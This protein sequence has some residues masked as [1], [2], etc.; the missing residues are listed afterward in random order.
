M[1]V[2]AR[3]FAVLLVFGVAVATAATP[4]FI[5][6][7]GYDEDGEQYAQLFD[8]HPWSVYD[9]FETGP[10]DVNLDGRVDLA[11]LNIVL[12]SMGKEYR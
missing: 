2:G 8:H 5:E 12:A 7:V 1:S 6:V 10:G 9:I 3:S 4:S 11:D